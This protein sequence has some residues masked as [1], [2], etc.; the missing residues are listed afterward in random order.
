[1][2]RALRVLLGLCLFAP[3]TAAAH[4]SSVVY[5]DVTVSPDR[6]SVELEVKIAARDLTEV[7]ELDP[8]NAPGSRPP[9]V[10]EAEERIYR[11]VS[12][13]VTAGCVPSQ[14]PMQVVRLRD[15]PYAAIRW[16]ERCAEPLEKLDLR[17][18]LFFDGD[19]LH[20]S[21]LRFTFGDQTKAFLF[22]ADTRVFEW[23]APLSGFSAFL[24][25]GVEHILFGPDHILFL[26]SLLLVVVIAKRG[27]SFERQDAWL[28]TKS[29]LALV[30]AFTLAHSITLITAALDVIPIHER[31]VESII[32]L[33]IV[34]VAIE[35]IVKPESRHR[36]VVTFAFGL[37][38]GMGFASMLQVLLPDEGLVVPVLA[39]NLGV[40]LGQLALVVVSL[41]LLLGVVRAA[42]AARYRR[43]IMPALCVLIAALGAVWLVER[44]FDLSIVA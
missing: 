31:W 16:T 15:G 25:S 38:H 24:V 26:L 39:F 41:P 35:N 27:D 30:T 22:S 17:Y 20:T 5:S 14:G 13:R 28:S 2:K 10:E 3:A 23:E 34:Y 12:A 40:E 11:Y 7:K 32:A 8:A 44:A 42:G 18:D 43:V 1:M 33:S 9:T 19:P 21:P 37:L 4:Q 36:A 29:T 6:Q